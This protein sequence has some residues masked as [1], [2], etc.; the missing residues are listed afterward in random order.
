MTC[1]KCKK[2]SKVVETRQL[3]GVRFRR[4]KCDCSEVWYTKEVRV[5]GE[6]HLFRKAPIA[7]PS[8]RLSVPVEVNGLVVTRDSPDWLKRVALQLKY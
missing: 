2:H 8:P 4:R 7:K 1:K 6:V 5:P 3:N